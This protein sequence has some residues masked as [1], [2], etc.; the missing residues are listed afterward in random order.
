MKPVPVERST[1]FFTVEIPSTLH[2]RWKMTA[3]KRKLSMAQ[4]TIDA[5]SAYLA[6]PRRT[7]GHA[8]EGA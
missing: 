2:Y 3:L 5:M 6:K 8:Q 1:K 7:N 4:M